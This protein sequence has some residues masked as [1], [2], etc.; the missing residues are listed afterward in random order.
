VIG[1]TTPAALGADWLASALDQPAYAWVI[2]PLGVHLERV[3][4]RWLLELF[5][6]PAEFGGILTTGATVA[7]FVG[8]GA[9]RT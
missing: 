2:S 7:N 5:E 9:A 1:G 6:L 3:A 8:L 4:L